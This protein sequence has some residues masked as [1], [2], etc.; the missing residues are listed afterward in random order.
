MRIPRLGWRIA[1]L[2]N[3][4]K[5]YTAYRVEF[6]LEIL[7]GALVPAAIQWVLWYAIFQVGG[8]HEVAGLTYTQMLHYTL[9]SILF[10]Q[11]RGGDQDFDLAEMIR[12]GSLSNYLIRPVNVVE[13]VYIR[14][15]A[16]K[17]FLAGLCLLIGF[18][19]GFWGFWLDMSPGRL[20]GAM[21]LALLG[22]II[23]FQ[24]GAVLA[25]M[26][27]AWEDAYGVLMV[28]N[29]IVSILSGELIPL[30]LF[31]LAWAWIWKS[32]PF[33]LY[34]FGPT[35]YALGQWTHLEFSGHLGIALLW[36]V[37]LWGVIRLSWGVGIRRYV[38]LGG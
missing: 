14:G 17:I 20:L 10:S 5:D 35:Q 4:F 22:N 1:A 33:Y 29:L 18:A 23:H 19:I 15:V 26:A 31:P 7:G 6:L 21:F 27:F 37:A 30:T 32:L 16:P 34:V 2:S 38:S 25:A 13:F 9:V 8:A 28:K 24:I 11:I 3:G 36:I 12:T